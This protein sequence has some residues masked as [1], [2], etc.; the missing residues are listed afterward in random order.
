MVAA[1]NL[2]SRMFCKRLPHLGPQRISLA[3]RGLRA[4]A[5]VPAGKEPEY[6]SGKMSGYSVWHAPEPFKLRNG[7]EIPNLRIAYETWGQLNARRDN[8]ILLQCGMSASS[9]ACS[10]SANP[11]KGWW[12][13]YIGPGRPLD[14]NL[15]H[16][17]CTNNLGGC[18]GSSGPSS[19]HPD[20]RHYGSRF[21]RFEVHDQVAAQFALLDYLGIDRL[22]ACVGASLG[23][24]QSVCSAALFP[25][26]VAKFVTMSACAK[27]FP[28]SMAFRHTQ[29]QAVMSDPNWNNG[30]YYDGPLPA[31]GLRL[32]RQ[33]GTITY[34]SGMEWQQRFGQRRRGGTPEGLEP[35]FEIERYLM[36]QGEKW[37]NNYD[38]N[39]MLWISKAMDAFTLEAPGEDGKPSL[40]A[41]LKKAMQPALVIG[42][43][44][45]VLFPVWQQKQIADCLR[46]AGNTRVAYYELDTVYGHDAFLLDA[47]SIGP[48]V[49]GHLEQE[50][51]GAQH[52]WEDMAASAGRILQ[53]VSK[54]GN[55]ADHMRDVFRAV[56]NGSDEVDR[57]R[58]RHALAISWHTTLNE[59]AID[60]V[61]TERL[62][63]SVKLPEFLETFEV[64]T[65]NQ[66]EH[67]VY[68][69]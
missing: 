33:I 25:E 65:R 60:K 28:G 32:A 34:R 42:V 51:G 7:A 29:R 5:N 63:E 38:P 37:V 23:G 36:H 19:L 44:H 57:E 64:L 1:P 10:N 47:V 69:P 12:E 18:F 48:A 22:H 62:P 17:I 54:R 14:T 6:A 8:V 21:P 31:A 53:A 3:V 26:R 68:L 67:D 66:R 55:T 39:S 24:M 4:A 20:G 61:F 56:A 59:E 30:N 49:K 35:E 16:I 2:A 50:P 45:D 52:I 27:S 40:E 43:Q 41:G 13:E 15:F 9:H 58:L 11:A 46:A